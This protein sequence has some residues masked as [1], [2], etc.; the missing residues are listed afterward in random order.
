MSFRRARHYL[1]AICFLTIILLFFKPS[2]AFMNEPYGFSGIKWGSEINKFKNLKFQ[3][4]KG[5]NNEIKVYVMDNDIRSFGG[6]E[7][8]RIEYEF[9]NGKFVSVT[10]KVKDLCN[11]ITLKKYCFREFGMGIELIKGLEQ[12]FWVGDKSIILLISKQEIN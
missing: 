8:D 9:Y 5:V 11:F 12:Y 1:A 2:C 7:I 3:Y 4:S 6:A 10:L